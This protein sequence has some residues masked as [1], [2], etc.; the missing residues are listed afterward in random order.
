MKEKKLLTKKDIEDLSWGLLR[1]IQ[2]YYG[3][4]IETPDEVLKYT[5]LYKKKCNNI[6]RFC[7]EYIVKEE[8]GI[9]K[10]KDVKNFITQEKIRN[11][12][13][14]KMKDDDIMIGIAEE[15]DTEY[16]EKK[17]IRMNGKIITIRHSIIGY[18][19]NFESEEIISEE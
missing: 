13:F 18:R 1:I 4:Y 15:L 3:K 6:F 2:E 5:E 16:I 12:Y 7:N 14:E 11:E 9:L 8:N 19:I 17:N 10:K